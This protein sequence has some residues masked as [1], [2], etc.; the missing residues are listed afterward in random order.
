MPP[1]IIH[2]ENRADF[3][4]LLKEEKNIVV[5]AGADWCGPCKQ[6]T[7]YFD[8]YVAAYL[9]NKFIIV[10]L[11]VDS[12]RDLASY[13]KIKSIPQLFYYKDGSLENVMIGSDTKHLKKFLNGLLK[14][15]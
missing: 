15:L 2:L 8:E 9:T 1:R 11:D 6:I 7:P 14:N 5:K 12:G 13:L 4:E 10:K 3:K